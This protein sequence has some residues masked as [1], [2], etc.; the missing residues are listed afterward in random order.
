MHNIYLLST[1]QKFSVI[2]I[3]LIV[4]TRGAHIR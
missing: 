2:W 4:T 1:F 3:Q